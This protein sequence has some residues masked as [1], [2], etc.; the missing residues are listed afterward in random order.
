MSNFSIKSVKRVCKAADTRGLKQLY[1]FLP[2]QIASEVNNSIYPITTT[3]TLSTNEEYSDVEFDKLKGSFEEKTDNDNKGGD[4]TTTTINVLI[5]NSRL[6]V[7]TLIARLRNRKV[8][9]LINDFGNTWRY[10]K[11]MQLSAVQKIAK[12]ENNY[13]LTFTAKNT[14]QSTTLQGQIPGATAPNTNISDIVLID[15]NGGKWKLTVT[16][17]GDLVT[18]QVNT[19]N[20]QIYY[21]INETPQ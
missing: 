2:S 9:T 5:S 8:Y 21:D 3:L 11:N 4:Y 17:N 19:I 15:P 14:T 10:T 1:L 20:G 16:V 7:D 18:T 12:G 13:Q 6:D